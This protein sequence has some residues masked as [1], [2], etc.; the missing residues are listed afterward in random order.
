MDSRTA[1]S[2]LDVNSQ[3]TLDEI[4]K[5]YRKLALKYHPDKQRNNPEKAQEFARKFDEIRKA[6]DCL[7][8]IMR[9]QACYGINC[10]SSMFGSYSCFDGCVFPNVLSIRESFS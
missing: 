1:Y 6:H 7:V 4:K 10:F 8:E 5:A 3:S 2:L 9:I